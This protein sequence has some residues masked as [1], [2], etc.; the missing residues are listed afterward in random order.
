M[1]TVLA[2]LLGP[3]LRARA[4]RGKEIADR[5]PERRGI[6]PT[7]RPDGPLVWLHAASVGETMSVLPVIARLAPVATA[8]PTPLRLT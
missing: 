8:R 3:H 6:D 2:P 4:R 7:Q 5:L 1:A